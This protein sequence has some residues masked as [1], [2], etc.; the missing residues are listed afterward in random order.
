MPKHGAPR[1]FP[2]RLR[3]LR[4][5]LG[6]G[7]GEFAAAA[8][9]QAQTIRN[10]EERGSIPGVNTLVN[11]MRTLGV[12]EWEKV[13]IW[14]ADVASPPPSW[15]D[16]EG[17]VPRLDMTGKNVAFV[18]REPGIRIARPWLPRR[19]LGRLLRLADA[20]QAR[21]DFLEA[22]RLEDELLEVVV[23]YIGSHGT[24]ISAVGGIPPELP[25]DRPTEPGKAA[26]PEAPSDDS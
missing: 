1:E 19:A 14:L 13:A 10:W 2:E 16:T 5:R 22:A 3:R 11:A 25:D 12:A 4:R 18:A 9:L 21:G 7:I 6:L 20:A 23:P 24:R 17:P 8:M 26:S 15:L